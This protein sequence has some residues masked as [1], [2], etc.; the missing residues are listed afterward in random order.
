MNGFPPSFSRFRT[1]VWEP[2]RRGFSV[3]LDIVLEVWDLFYRNSAFRLVFG[4]MGGIAV[5]GAAVVT[6]LDRPIADRQ[7]TNIPD[8]I[9]WAFVTM[10]TTG[11]GDITPKSHA[12][13]T[14]AI[15]MMFA[16]IALTSFFTATVASIFVTQRLKEGRGLERI[17]W[18]GHTLVCGWNNDV[19]K[20]IT[21]LL[22]A[23]K[24]QIVLVNELNE[25]QMTE[26]LFKYGDKIKFV[27]GN[28]CLE[29]V[30][31]RANVREAE[32]AI[33]I[34]DMAGGTAGNA[35]E[36]TII[37]TLAIKSMEPHVMT[38]AELLNRD[39]EQHLRRAEVDDV[40]VSGEDSGLLLASAIVARGVP[41]VVRE[42][43]S[44]D[45]GNSFYRCDIPRQFVGRPSIELSEYFR[46]QHQAILMALVTEE[47]NI[48]LNDILGGDDSLIDNFIRQK[49]AEAQ[50]TGIGG[51]KQKISTVVN[52]KDDH[53]I[54]PEYAAIVVANAPIEI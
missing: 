54:Q 19:E 27:R 2:T 8:A 3:V 50:K 38:C 14:V 16:G 47:A 39:N 37:A 24:K 6:L 48:E 31:D 26:V 33:V 13:R 42:L 12:A 45:F 9:W 32:A 34:A 36:R 23:G 17:K 30:L 15:L 5:A 41:Q 51:E 4:L 22:R 28:Y 44:F 21:G 25:E 20:V 1:L 10:T 52:P 18:Q 43:L 49:F 7:I 11:Y 46:T 40:I 29:S 53:V 35:D